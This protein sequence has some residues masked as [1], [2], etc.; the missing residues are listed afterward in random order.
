MSVCGRACGG[1]NKVVGVLVRSDRVW[2]CFWR[3]GYVCM[4]M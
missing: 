4:S 2:G 3:H 1:R